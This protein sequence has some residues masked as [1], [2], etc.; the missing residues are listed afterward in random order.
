M[1]T[2]PSKITIK[3]RKFL[4]AY[5]E[6]GN[7]TEAAMQAYDCKDRGSAQSLGS[8]TLSNLVNGP[9]KERMDAAGLSDEYLMSIM[10]DGLN[11][12][13][14]EIVKFEGKINDEKAFPD[15]RTRAKYAELILKW[16]GELKE[17]LIHE[18][19][20]PVEFTGDNPQEYINDKIDE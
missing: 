1:H 10:H 11:A 13:K 15:H 8:E 4:K 17:H 18:G 12:D 7:A 9:I 20:V 3:Q 16:K 14:V 6:T 2:T 5:L 19:R